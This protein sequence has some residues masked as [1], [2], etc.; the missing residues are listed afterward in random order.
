[1]APKKTQETQIYKSGV[2]KINWETD[3]AN[4]K[5]NSS[6]GNH[7]SKG[8][9]DLEKLNLLRPI[10]HTIKHGKSGFAKV[11]ALR[12]LRALRAFAPLRLRAFASYVPWFL[13]ALITRFARLICYLRARLTRDIKSLI[14]GNFKMF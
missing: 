3:K 14:K 8:N 13:S 5:N 11:R 12:A 2:N 7:K 1:M 6:N 4:N 9:T 10:F